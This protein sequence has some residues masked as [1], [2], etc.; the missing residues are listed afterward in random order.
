MFD[1]DLAPNQ[2]NIMI[3]I[4]LPMKTNSQLISTLVLNHLTA[5]MAIKQ[6]RNVSGV[7]CQTHKIWVHLNAEN[8]EQSCQNVNN[9]WQRSARNAVLSYGQHKQQEHFFQLM[10]LWWLQIWDVRCCC[11][12]CVGIICQFFHKNMHVICRPMFQ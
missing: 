9:S 8:S 11:Y 5:T 3:S 4:V 12:W 10:W 2:K 7:R 1:S 6:G